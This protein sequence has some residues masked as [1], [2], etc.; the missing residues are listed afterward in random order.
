MVVL[1]SFRVVCLPFLEQD[2][3][4]RQ[5]PETGGRQERQ[6]DPDRER[7]QA[8]RVELHTEHQRGEE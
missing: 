1:P 5:D 6:E 7:S 4:G 3:R 8:G 2:E